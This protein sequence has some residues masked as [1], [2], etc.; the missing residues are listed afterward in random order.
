LQFSFDLLNFTSQIKSEGTVKVDYSYLADGTKAG[1]AGTSGTGFYYLGSFIYNRSKA[2]QS[3]AFGGGRIRKSG[4]TYRV[5]YHITDHLGSVRA[6]VENGSVVERNDFYPFG[7]RHDNGFPRLSANRWRFSGKEEQDAAFGVA[8]SDFG[9]RFYDRSA[10]WNA[11]DPMAEKYYAVSPY[12]YC[13]DN[14]VHF[15]DPNGKRVLIWYNDNGTRRSFQYSG[16]VVIHSNSF[17]NAVIEAYHYNKVNW[18]IAGYAGKS[19]LAT[20]VEREE[21]VNISYSGAFPDQFDYTR[22]TIYWNPAKGLFSEGVITSPATG[23]DHE[24][25]H[26]NYYLDNPIKQI[27]LSKTND[28][29]F[30][31][32]EERRVIMGS[33]QKT[34]RANGEIKG[35]QV[36]R[37]RYSGRSVIVKGTTSTL[38]NRNRTKELWKEQEE[39]LYE[40]VHQ[41]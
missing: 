29:L 3:V 13:I 21:T 35:N 9:A 34:A 31:K 16:G 18:N 12:V 19:P 25:D 36:T 6:I 41:D 5:D 40:A 27:R 38:V 32:A 14:P 26:A 39:L 23:L 28:V 24:A 2:L 30:G 7:T 20:L 1:A 17:V 10:A 11:I 15:V 22:R 37:N 8:Y 4:S 33:E